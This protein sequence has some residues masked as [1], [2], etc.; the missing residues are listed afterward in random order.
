MSAVL[1]ALTN[2]VTKGPKQYP[3]CQCNADKVRAWESRLTCYP[4]RVAAAKAE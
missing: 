1:R 4:S 2:V 3:S